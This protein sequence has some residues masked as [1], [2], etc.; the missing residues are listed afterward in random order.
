[1]KTET[2]EV[3]IPGERK[4]PVPESPTCN[5]DLR[6]LWTKEEDTA[7]KAMLLMA[8][9][10]PRSEMRK[11]FEKLFPGRSRQ[12][13][14]KRIEKMQRKLR[15]DGEKNGSVCRPEKAQHHS[16]SPVPKLEES[17]D[18]DDITIPKRPLRQAGKKGEVN[19][20]INLQEFLDKTK[21]FEI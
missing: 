20:R 16:V 17:S 12:A 5:S 6:K 21:E 2:D 4:S 15:A 10:G 13:M 7:I 9:S 8:P 11:T 14:G 19:R 3:D 1:M 18:C